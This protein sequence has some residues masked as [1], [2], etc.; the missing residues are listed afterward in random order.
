MSRPVKWSILPLIYITGHHTIQIS[1]SNHETHRNAPFVH[2]LGVV[3][4]PDDGVGDAGVDTEGTEKGAGVLH[5]RGGAGYEHGETDDAE[6]GAADVAEA[7][8]VRAVCEGA[9]ADC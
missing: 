5:G 6:D 7:A 9:D 3:G 2:T 4:G 8:L 1:P